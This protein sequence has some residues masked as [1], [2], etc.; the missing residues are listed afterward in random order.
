MFTNDAFPFNP[1][2]SIYFQENISLNGN[3]DSLSSDSRKKYEEE[4]A[5][6]KAKYLKHRQILVSNR[7][8]A[9]R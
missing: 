8:Q 9:E 6:M 7:E 4:I 5:E 1:D 2:F 3:S